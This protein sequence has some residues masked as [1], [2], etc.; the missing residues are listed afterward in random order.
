MNQNPIIKSLRDELAKS[1]AVDFKAE[2]DKSNRC[3]ESCYH[4]CLNSEIYFMYGHEAAS[5]RLLGLL[6]KAVEMA[7][8]YGNESNWKWSDY[9]KNMMCYEDLTF[10]ECE[11]KSENHFLAGKKAREFLTTLNK[12]I[13]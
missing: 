3:C 2:C 5:T 4:K 12:E 7:E 13:K 9:N 1:K 10:V 11:D 6:E 8:F